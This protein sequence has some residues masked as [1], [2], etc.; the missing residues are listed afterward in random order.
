M[1]LKALRG[2][3]Y[4]SKSVLKGGVFEAKPSDVR[5]LVAAKIAQHYVEP[6]QKKVPAIFKP[7]PEFVSEHVNQADELASFESDPPMDAAEPERVKRAYKR[8]D[9]RAE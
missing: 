9:M 3:R 5:L 6:P 7:I 2:L 8:R 1:K 4:A